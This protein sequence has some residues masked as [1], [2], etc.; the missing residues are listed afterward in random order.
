MTQGVSIKSE[1]RLPYRSM[2]EIYVGDVLRFAALQRCSSRSG[3]LVKAKGLNQVA[4]RRDHGDR[5]RKILCG[6]GRMCAPSGGAHRAN[7]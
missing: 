3:L 2:L 6:A 4:N 5:N 7:R 1:R